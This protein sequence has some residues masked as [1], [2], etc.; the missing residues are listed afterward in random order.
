MVF[1]FTPLLALS[2][3]LRQR[4]S[5][6]SIKYTRYELEGERPL[7]TRRYFI[8]L[9]A[10]PGLAMWGC[11]PKPQEE[12]PM[13]PPLSSTAPPPG[14]TASKGVI[15]LSVLTMTNPFFK[16]IADNMTEEA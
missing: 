7:L 9:C 4:S 3:V 15:G 6:D 14:T 11:G 10:L 5:Y 8:A 1:N 16:E 13:K 2:L 12:S